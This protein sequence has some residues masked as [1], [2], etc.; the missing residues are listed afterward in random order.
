MGDIKIGN[1]N[2]TLKLGSADVSAAYIGS[3]LVYSSYTPTQIYY[4]DSL[5]GLSATM[6]RVSTAVTLSETHNVTFG[7]TSSNTYTLLFEN[8]NW[9][10]WRIMTNGAF[11]PESKTLLTASGGYYTIDFGGQYDCLG[12][13]GD[14]YGQGTVWYAPFDFEI[15]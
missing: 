15:S 14:M 10:N 7:D 11:T 4:G 13:D 12:A 2:I 9:Y 3:T 8:G 1:S 5:Y 6:M